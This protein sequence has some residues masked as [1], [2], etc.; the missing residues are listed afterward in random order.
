MS[1]QVYSGY[2]IRGHTFASFQ[3]ELE[4]LRTEL[5]AARQRQC[6]VNVLRMA[7]GAYFRDAVDAAPTNYLRIAADRYW[8]AA[9][10]DLCVDDTPNPFVNF[11]FTVQVFEVQGRLLAQISTCQRNFERVWVSQAWCKPFAYWDVP[12]SPAPQ[13]LSTVQ[14]H[15]RRVLWEEALGQ[16]QA[17][18]VPSALHVLV[19][20]ELGQLSFQDD[21]FEYILRSV[22]NELR[23][24]D[25]TTSR[26]APS[27][28]T[29]QGQTSLAG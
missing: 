24:E 6:A 21:D 8:T 2:E 3:P 5:Q 1:L 27:L 9:Q 14:W 22:V 26:P 10:H 18:A 4:R 19:N 23:P 17:L 16:S 15:E 29:L 25:K 20:R 11:T 12:D 28:Q 7:V 13:E